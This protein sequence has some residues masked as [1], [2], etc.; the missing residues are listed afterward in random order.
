M[1]CSVYFVC[2]VSYV[3]LVY[4]VF[5]VCGIYAV[6]VAFCVYTM[7]FMCLWYKVYS[8]YSCYA[9]CDAVMFKRTDHYRYCVLT[10]Q[11]EYRSRNE[12]LAVTFIIQYIGREACDVFD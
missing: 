6:C 3:S 8:V 10:N 7:F 4:T 11:D 1:M 9:V 2:M 12:S 5:V